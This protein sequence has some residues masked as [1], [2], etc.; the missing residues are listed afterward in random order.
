MD[1]A[2]RST[3]ASSGEIVVVLALDQP[4]DVLA[5]THASQAGKVTLVR[6]TGVPSTVDPGA[7]S[8]TPPER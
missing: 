4:D 3:I 7:D 6:S 5:V 8:Y 1:D 2:G